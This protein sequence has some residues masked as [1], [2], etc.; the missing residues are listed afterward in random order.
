MKMNRK[1]MMIKAFIIS[2]VMFLLQGIFTLIRT[3]V[4]IEFYGT[5]VNGVVQLS[6]QIF[7]YLVLLESGLGA[8]YLFKMYKPMAKEEYTKVN[9]LYKGL[10]TSLKKIAMLM[11]VVMLLISFIYPFIVNK[12]TL[13]YIQIAL[14][15][16]LLGIRFILPYYFLISKKNLLYV[17]EK[18]YLVDLVDGIA[19]I[20]ILIIEIIMASIF[21]I[22]ILITLTIGIIIILLTNYIYLMLIEK[23]CKQILIE[24]S[25]PN[26][27]ATSMTKDII[28][29]QI[30]SV[31]FSST[32][33]IIL[34]ILSNLKNVTIYSAYNMV[35]TY[36]INLI[37]R[38]VDNLRA[39]FGKKIVENEKSAIQLFYE[40]ISINYLFVLISA[41][42]FY[43]FI[44]DF[45]TL[46]IGE[47]FTL[48]AGCIIIWMLIYIH[49][50]IMPVVYIAR[51]AKGLYKQS[52][53]YTL[54]QA[55]VNIILSLL[56]VQ[57]F[58]IFGLLLGTVLATYLILIPFNYH[59]V[60][61]EVLKSK[62][63]LLLY[64]GESILYIS[65]AIIT[66]NY[67]NIHIFHL[68]GISWETFIVKLIVD[69][70]FLGIISFSLFFQFNKYFK[71]LIRRFIR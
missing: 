26:Y 9:G 23:N 3:K 55:I 25:K 22:D 42:I 38:V 50:C 47:E 33:N 36:P 63:N 60:C 7:N 14:I 45:I 32:D 54:W 53:H 58:G 8:A 48:G 51:D 19:N 68:V 49:R 52:K 2:V 34:S 59:L 41:P 24:N 40:T 21:K 6:H 56:F 35:M 67:V 15:L 69:L 37:N 30:S 61:K 5:D 57:K 65:I 44:N 20:V 13:S 28:V 1:N 27:E 66:L 10:V 46:W 39:T 70:C 62:N 18:K 4:F 64:L 16:A 17:Y 11:L 31:V 43:L 71:N 29:H 12:G